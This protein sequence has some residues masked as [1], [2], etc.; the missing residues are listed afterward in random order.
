[1]VAYMEREAAA[2]GTPWYSIARHHAGFASTVCAGSRRWRQVWSDHRLKGLPAREV[3][4]L[5][6][7]RVETNWLTGLRGRLSTYSPVVLAW[8]AGTHPSVAATGSRSLRGVPVARFAGL[9]R[10]TRT[11]TLHVGRTG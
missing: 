5:A 10:R 4:A 11:R 7:G 8:P 9:R 1:M 2:H 3:M 6:Q